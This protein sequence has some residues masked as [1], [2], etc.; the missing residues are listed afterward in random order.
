M[1]LNHIIRLK[2][3]QNLCNAIYV[4]NIK[5]SDQMLSY[6]F[7]L[8]FIVTDFFALKN[9]NSIYPIDPLDLVIIII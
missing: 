1:L 3:L 2:S 4:N 5:S 6:C 8:K 7:L 9:A